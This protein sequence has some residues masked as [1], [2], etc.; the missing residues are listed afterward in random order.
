MVKKLGEKNWFLKYHCKIVIW[1]SLNN[2]HFPMNAVEVLIWEPLFVK[3]CLRDEGYFLHSSMEIYWLNS[4]IPPGNY[5][6]LET[7]KRV[8]TFIYFLT[9][10]KGHCRHPTILSLRRNE[11]PFRIKMSSL[12]NNWSLVFPIFLTYLM[13]K[14]SIFNIRRGSNIFMH[15]V[16]STIPW[17][18]NP[19]LRQ[20]ICWQF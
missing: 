8:N 5:G 20:I 11:N 7:R 18:G 13:Q 17:K 9:L 14:M 10:E 16:I 1:G 2:M 19:I 12:P 3:I 6:I 15:Y 4:N